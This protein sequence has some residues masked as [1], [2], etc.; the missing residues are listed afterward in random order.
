MGGLD[1]ARGVG[2][3]EA[4]GKQSGRGGM[5]SKL[6]GEGIRVS[7]LNDREDDGTFIWS[8]E[9]YGKIGCEA[10]DPRGSRSVTFGAPV[11]LPAMGIDAQNTHL[12]DPQRPSIRDSAEFPH[13][14]SSRWGN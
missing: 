8:E 2:V 4:W 13:Q 7:S 3:W 5:L 10:R 12:E 9:L 11:R 14:I 6:W 1:L